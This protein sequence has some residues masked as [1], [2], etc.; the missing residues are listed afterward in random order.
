MH[1]FSL[2]LFELLSL[3]KHQRSPPIFSGVRVTRSLVVCVMFCRSLSVLLFSFSFV[4]CVVG[5]SLITDS[6]YP[7]CIFKLFLFLFICCIP[8]SHSSQ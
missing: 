5:P 3:P 6:D 2:Q 4:Y 1:L 7:F 8:V